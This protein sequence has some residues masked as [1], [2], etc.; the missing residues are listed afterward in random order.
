MGWAY[1]RICPLP[2][3][4]HPLPTPIT[5]HYPSIAGIRAP[6]RGALPLLGPAAGSD[7]SLRRM[8]QR[9]RFRCGTGKLTLQSARWN[10]H[11][12]TEVLEV[13]TKLLKS[14]AS[15]SYA[16][17]GSHVRTLQP[18][19]NPNFQVTTQSREVISEVIKTGTMNSIMMKLSVRIS[20]FDW[21]R[22]RGERSKIRERYSRI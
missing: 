12:S 11:N 10:A 3:H 8:S 1:W 17:E 19:T 15:L 13:A 22:L 7:G 2:T 20:D 18:I 6:I 16:L 5:T 4:Y 21:A 9:R 14:I